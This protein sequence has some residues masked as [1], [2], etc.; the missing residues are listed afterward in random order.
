MF[1]EK[2]PILFS[3]P[4]EYDTVEIYL[5]HD[6]HYGN[7]C[8]DK[9]KW[10]RL[11]EEILSAPNKFCVIV[12]DMFEN[13]LPTS[14][15]NIFTQFATPQEQK[16]WITA[17]FIDLKD[18][19]IGII[20]GNHEYNRTT[21]A[22]GLYPLYDCALL[23]GIGERYRNSYAFVD[24]GVGKGGHTPGR[25][26]RYVGY[27]IHRAKDSKMYSTADSI[28]GIDFMVYGHDH[29]PKD[30]PRKKLVYDNKN[31]FVVEKDIEVLD[32]GAFLDYGGYAPI[33]G[34]RPLSSKIYKLVL[35][36]STKSL[37]TIGFYLK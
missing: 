28:D 37:S 10:K 15:G 14:K 17:Q 32:G 18:R 30:H 22:C 35:D 29:D 16:E 27:L 8:F 5:I 24:I 11:K 23:A 1:H 19:I 13:A 31:K 3:C 21:K 36:G 26:V 33:S 6:L 7:E 9:K 2:K 4:P 34:Y 20:P 25:Q 12:G